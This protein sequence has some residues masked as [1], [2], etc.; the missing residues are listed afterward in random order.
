MKRDD[1][2]LID[3]ILRAADT[4]AGYLHQVTRRMFN[5]NQMMRDAVVRQISI[6][7]EAASKLSQVFRQQHAD[8]PWRDIVGMR[9]LVIHNYGEID[10]DVVWDTARERVPE[11]AEYLRDKLEDDR[12]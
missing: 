7:G 3:D 10:W 6:I 4:I 5:A 12:G 9:N 1:P 11:L 8:V 2:S